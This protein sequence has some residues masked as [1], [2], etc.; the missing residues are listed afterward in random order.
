MP[1][2]DYDFI[3]SENYVFAH[4]NTGWTFVRST[5]ATIAVYQTVL[6]LDLISES[7]DQVRTN[8]ILG[9]TESRTIFNSTD[10]KMDFITA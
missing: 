2:D 7:R 1:I 8:E 6:D 10:L 9:S 3:L 5:P 4:G